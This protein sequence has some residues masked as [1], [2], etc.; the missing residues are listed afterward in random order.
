[1]AKKKGFG[2]AVKGLKDIEKSYSALAKIKGFKSS[3]G[4]NFK[5]EIDGLEDVAGFSKAMDALP[6]KIEAA[7][8][9][10]MQII[11]VLL[12]G[13]LDDAML[14]PIWQW[15]NDTRDIIDTGALMAS[16]RVTYSKATQNISIDYGEEYAAIVHYGGYIKSGY[17]PDVQIFY[18]AR[19]WIDSVL[20][21]GNG[22]PPFPFNEIY[23]QTF[24]NFFK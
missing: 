20:N 14:S 19:P 7:H 17:N 8:H 2:K 24:F 6:S 21:G 15:T 16:G 22:I 3:V 10:T 23:K 9:R 1:M 4:F 5:Y 13:A 11:A 18:P 12:K